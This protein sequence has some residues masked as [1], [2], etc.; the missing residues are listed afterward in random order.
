MAIREATRIVLTA[1]ERTT[2]AGWVRSRKA[3]QRLVE[4]ARLVLLAAAGVPSR[5]IAR[6]LGCA[7]GVVSKWR[8]RFARDRLA[9][10]A[11]APR[12]G[13]PR[14][15]GAP[16][17]RRILA[18]LDR[19]P[20]AGFARWTA[21]LL[22]NELGDVSDQYIWRFFARPTDRPR[23]AQVLAPEHRHRVRAGVSR[24]P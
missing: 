16:T 4:R 9:G 21:P 7:R 14:T 10:L 22:A 8:L 15:Y 12:S 23:R 6:E 2:L 17:D 18:L 19:P 24:A 20:P 1:A 3:E 5:A 11:D 13:K